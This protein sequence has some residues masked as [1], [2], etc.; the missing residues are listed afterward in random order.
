MA[1]MRRQS[2]KII[3]YKKPKNINIG[4]IV[5][6]VIFVYLIIVLGQYIMKPKIQI[7]EVQDGDIAN[8]S[9]YTGVILRNETVVNTQYTGYVNYYIREKQKA[10]VGNLI[11]TVDENGTMNEY[12]SQSSDG[13]SRLSDDNLK[14]LK[15]LLSEFSSSYSD[16]RFADVYDVSSTLNSTLIEYLNISALQELN[17]SENAENSLSFQRCY[18]ET[19]GIVIYSTDGLEG[20]TAE[21]VTADTFSQEH[22]QKTIHTGGELT[23]SGSPVYKLITDDAWSV[24]IPLSEDELSDYTDVTSVT[25]RFTEKGLETTADFSV[26]TGADGASYGKIDL[27]KYMIQFAGDR[28]VEIEVKNSQAEGLK[29]PRTAL[30]SKEFYVVPLKFLT[31]G[32]NSAQEGFYKE[33]YANDGT[34]SIE[35]VTADIYRETEEYYYVSADDFQDGDY[36]VLPDS[37]ERYQIGQ[38]ESLQ[39]VY[40]VNRGYAVFKQVEILDENSEYCIVQKN[41]DY[42]LRTYDQIV[43]NASMVTEHDILR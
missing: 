19:S 3:R 29:V 17:D 41:M 26:I 37:N 4:V 15:S 20:L 31:T 42:G 22:Y 21:Q 10:A 33:V 27:T 16:S 9:Y 2:K 18:A 25:V 38:K 13:G 1:K 35:F 12:L 5:F 24:V 34:S 6:A 11:Y 23:E 7:Y 28:F 30:T 8:D 14:E 43:L 40:N 39:G 32:G 36:I